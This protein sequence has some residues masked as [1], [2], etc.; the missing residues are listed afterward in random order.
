MVMYMGRPVTR[1]VGVREVP[2]EVRSLSTMNEPDYVDMFNMAVA[3]DSAAETWARAIYEDTLGARGRFVFGVILGLELARAKA[4][5]TVAGWRIAEHGED[6]IRLEAGG[7]RLVGQIVVRAV[8]GQLSVATFLQY[9]SRL[10][11]TVW[12]LW[13]TLHRKAMLG[14]LR[15]AAEIVEG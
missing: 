4:P 2:E 15:D 9:V 11:S 6:W 12:T 5:G 8:D 7:G 13:S 1:V 10:G 3:T 14:M